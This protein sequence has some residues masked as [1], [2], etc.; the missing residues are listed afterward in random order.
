LA[1]GQQ[2]CMEH[3]FSAVLIPS[4][5]FQ[6]FGGFVDLFHCSAHNQVGVRTGENYDSS[7][8]LC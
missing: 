7:L 6:V 2:S 4:V 1:E 5:L 8:V 3:R